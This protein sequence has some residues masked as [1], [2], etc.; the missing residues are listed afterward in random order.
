MEQYVNS[1]YLERPPVLV[2][3]IVLMKP[4]T[5][6]P[7]MWAFFCGAIASGATQLAMGDIGRMALGML[8]AGP[9]MC[10]LS[11]VINDYFDREIDAINEPDRLIPS[12]MVSMLQVMLTIVVLSLV[13]FAIALFL[14]RGVILLSAIGLFAAMAYSAPP[15]RAKR[16]GWSGN[17]LVAISYEGLAWV[18]GHLA[19]A[20]LTPASLLIVSFY[21]FGTIGIMGINDYKSIDGDRDGG[22][23]T[24]PVLYGPFRAAWLIVALMNIAQLG[25]ITAFIAWQNWIIAAGLIGILLIQLPM[26]RFFLRDPL[27][28]Y[29]K[30]SAI[31]VSFFVW[32]M[33]VAAIGLRAV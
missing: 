32:G 20:E 33:L 3:S 15:I 24:M 29:L 4:V 1:A 7:P 26:Q 2:R 10:G 9:I 19:F 16:N 27:E 14:G 22:I 17:T 13:A 12:G 6:F 23:F 30:F 21:V 31:G 18:A 25:V 11:Q 5:W 8:F 28:N